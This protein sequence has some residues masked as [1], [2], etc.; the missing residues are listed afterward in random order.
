MLIDSSFSKS[1]GALWP[2]LTGLHFA[3]KA[4]YLLI[5]IETY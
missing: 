4:N 5:S 3:I 2:I 1:F